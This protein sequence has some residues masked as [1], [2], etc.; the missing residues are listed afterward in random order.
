MLLFILLFGIICGYIYLQLLK[1]WYW[2]LCDVLSALRRREFDITHICWLPLLW[3]LGALLAFSPIAFIRG[4]LE[5]YS[6]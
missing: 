6:R 4:V 1:F 3:I 5:F 2:M